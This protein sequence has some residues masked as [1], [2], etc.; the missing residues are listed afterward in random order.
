MAKL[1]EPIW[2]ENGQ[3][4]YVDK[5]ALCS[6]G[7]KPS[8]IIG[9]FLRILQY[10]FSDPDNISEVKL[11]DYIWADD[12]PTTNTVASKIFIAPEW[13]SN[14]DRNLQQRP[15]IIV[16]NSG[17]AV[18]EYAIGNKVT[19]S[20]NKGILRGTTYTKN[21]G[22]TIDLLC[23]GETAISSLVLAEEVFFRMLHFAPTM[24]EDIQLGELEVQ[25][26]GSAEKFDE[27]E[28]HFSTAVR[29]LWKSLHNWTLEQK[30]PILKDIR[31]TNQLDD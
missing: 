1:P 4:T 8:I 29:I 24:K 16:K 28:E 27:H 22:G 20:T 2:D 13:N 12:S 7:P 5:S 9:A 25:S 30:S 3:P 26:V 23:I 14:A 10:H 18:H 6:T 21:I 11:K 19:A 31:T 15:A 17:L